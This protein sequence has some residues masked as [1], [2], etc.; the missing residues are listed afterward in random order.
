MSDI[1]KDSSVLFFKVTQSK[2]PK[3]LAAQSPSRVST[4]RTETPESSDAVSGKQR[5]LSRNEKRNKSRWKTKRN[6]TFISG[7]SYAIR[8]GT[9]CWRPVYCGAGEGRTEEALPGNSDGA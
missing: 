9:V 2:R 6:A 8:S 4:N 7:T 5:Q 3:Y 1:S